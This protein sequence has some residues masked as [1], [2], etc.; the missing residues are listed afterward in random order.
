[1]HRLVF[2]MENCIGCRLCQ[3]ACSGRHEGRFSP[4]EARLAVVSRYGRQ[5][6]VVEA[7]LCDACG[8]CVDACPTGA[9]TMGDGVPLL[10]NDLCDRCG[11]CAAE[12]PQEVISIKDDGLP[13]ICDH[14]GGQ[15]VCVA[16][17]P[18]G[19]LKLEEVSGQ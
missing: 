16:W 6:L 17:C 10:N 3:L 12:C 9:L 2:A 13:R 7:R 4:L 19:A 8:R 5:G 11:V 18:H 1:V 14:C 15:P